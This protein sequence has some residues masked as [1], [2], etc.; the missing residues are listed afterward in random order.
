MTEL[1]TIEDAEAMPAQGELDLGLHESNPFLEGFLVP[2]KTRMRRLPDTER[3]AIVNMSTGVI[4]GA[5][6]IVRTETLDA[7]AFT[8]I[9][10][11]Q[12]GLFFGLTSSSVKVLA[13]VWAEYGRKPGEDRVY[14][15]ERVAAQHAKRAGHTLSRAT[16]FRGRKD[17]IE[18][19]FIAAST[20]PN[21]YWI[22]PAVF[23]NGSRVKFITELVRGPEI[24]GPGELLP[25]EDA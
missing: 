21:L 1:I 5:A 12:I 25:G 13:A 14:M 22:N 7:E 10:Q 9:F 4:E 16:Y 3:H 18:A 11:A 8:K 24:V 20:E 2:T 23:F 19:Q 15:S 17:L 6:T